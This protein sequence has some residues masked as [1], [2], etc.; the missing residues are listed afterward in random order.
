MNW[1]VIQVNDGGERRRRHFGAAADSLESL[2]QKAKRGEY[3]RLSDMRYRDQ[4]GV[5]KRFNEWDA[6]V[7]PSIVINP[8]TIVTVMQS[9]QRQRHLIGKILSALKLKMIGGCA[10]NWFKI[11]LDNG[12][13]Q[14]YGYIGASADSLESLVE[15]ARGD[16]YIFL[17]SLR[18][19]DQRGMYKAWEDWDASLVP[20]VAIN[21]DTIVSVMQF[22]GDPLTTPSQPKG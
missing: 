6:S 13:G 2:L 12:T 21:P 11:M 10:M 20:R 16:E 7:V 17:D 8:R 22:K 15:K 4:R 3:I 19:H 18:Y 9:R 1:F 5:T 14:G